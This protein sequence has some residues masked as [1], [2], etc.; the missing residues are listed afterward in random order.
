MG[1]SSMAANNNYRVGSRSAPADKHII[2]FMDP[3]KPILST[4]AAMQPSTTTTTAA[5]IVTSP[6]ARPNARSLALNWRNVAGSLSRNA[7]STR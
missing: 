5:S 2:I 7:I 4:P 3:T 6:Y 1:L